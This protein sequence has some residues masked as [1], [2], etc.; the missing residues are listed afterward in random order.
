MRRNQRQQITGKGAFFVIWT[1]GFT[2]LGANLF[3]RSDEGL[4]GYGT[5]GMICLVLAI[6]PFVVW[7]FL[8]VYRLSDHTYTNAQ[9]ASQ[10]VPDLYQI[11]VRLAAE[12]GREP[13][14]IE[15]TQV[16]QALH[17]RK[18][19]AAGSAIAGVALLGLIDHTVHDP[20]L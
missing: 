19:E 17:N 16:Q 8:A 4:N 15:C 11:R 5:A 7:F 10:R 12:L 3:D 13:T 6:V 2:I 20:K 9:I 18:V 1:V 14:L